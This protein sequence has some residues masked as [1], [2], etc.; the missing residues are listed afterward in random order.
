[1]T[2]VARLESCIDDK[3]HADLK[4]DALTSVQKRRNMAKVS[5]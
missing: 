4:N 1:M 3:E 2:N 5:E